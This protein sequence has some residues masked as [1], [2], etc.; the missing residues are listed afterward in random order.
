MNYEQARDLLRP[1]ERPERQVISPP[2]DEST[3]R[4]DDTDEDKPYLWG[5]LSVGPVW[6][7]RLVRAG[8]QAPTPIQVQSYQLLVQR[9]NNNNNNNKPANAVLAAPTGSGKSLAYLLPLLT[10]L[11]VGTT[12]TTTTTTT[13]KGRRPD[14]DPESMNVLTKASAGLIGKV[15]IMTPTMELACQLQRIIVQL[16][17]QVEEEGATDGN[18]KQSINGSIFHVLQNLN[19]DDDNDARPQQ[20]QPLP[21]LTQ[22]ATSVNNSVPPVFIAGT[23]KLL[24]QLRKEIKTGTGKKPFRQKSDP[25]TNND[26]DFDDVTPMVRS[27]A[28]ALDTNLQTVVLDEADRL[29]QTSVSTTDRD[30]SSDAG[31]AKERPRRTIP[32]A[33]QLL[34]TLVFERRQ[35]QQ[36]PRNNDRRSPPSSS[37]LQ[38]IC[39]SATVGRSLR[40]QLMDIVG[41]SSMDKAATL[42]TADVRTKKDGAVRKSSLLPANL[43]H[44]YRLIPAAP[45]GGTGKSMTMLTEL[46]ATM[47]HLDPHPC[48][49]FPGPVGVERTQTYLQNADF[50]DVRGLSS[51]MDERRP[52]TAS[53]VSDWKSTPIYVVKER[54]GRGLDLPELKYVFVLGIPTNAASYAHLA[55][56]TA[57]G[58]QMG[59]AITIFEPSDAAKLSSIADTFGLT[60]SCLNE[61]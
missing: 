12:A 10:T 2:A 25:R 31:P 42:V 24:S 43:I 53:P 35:Q 55:G 50:L 3:N 9:T 58:D 11:N 54:L 14:K 13:T 44:A 47:Q 1:Y 29:L 17:A 51:L 36:Q 4:Y 18:N 32:P 23:P 61:D 48:L 5:G 45:G 8:Y 30:P 38:V 37:A 56:R 49:I 41:A 19:T 7:S 26:M 39:A 15:W 46:I 33:Q 6:K 16:T 40:R 27:V 59:T 28:K 52:G 57:R 60:L 20:Q 34:Q 21:L 22:I